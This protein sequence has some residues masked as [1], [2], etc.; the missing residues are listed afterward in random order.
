VRQILGTLWLLTWCIVLYGVAAPWRHLGGLESE[1]VR[2]LEWWSLCGGLAAGFIVGR[3]VRDWARS[4]AGR[5]YVTALR[6]VFYP[7]AFFTAAALIVMAAREERGAVGVA[8]T[9]FL[10]YWAGLDC[11]FGAVPLMEG[12][13]YRLTRPLDPEDDVED[14][15]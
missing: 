11:A 5:T 6:W 7:P 14:A 3:E 12:K 8:A 10:S 15:A 1:R 2:W 4:G 9:A 13:S